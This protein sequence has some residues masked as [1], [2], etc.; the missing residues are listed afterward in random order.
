MHAYQARMVGSSRRP[1]K[2]HPLVWGLPSDKFS[3]FL[4]RQIGACFHGDP[5]GFAGGK[6]DADVRRVIVRPKRQLARRILKHLH[7]VEKGFPEE[8]GYGPC[9]LLVASFLRMPSARPMNRYARRYG[10]RRRLPPNAIG[11]P[12]GSLSSL[13]H[14]AT[15]QTVNART[16]FMEDLR[17]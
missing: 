17:K 3:R 8:G 10:E 2:C 1:L 5:V 15:K 11:L 16:L 4:G 12:D 9:D 6:L 14:R 13:L 7:Q